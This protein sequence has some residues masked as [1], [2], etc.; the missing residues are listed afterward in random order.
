[1]SNSVLSGVW[2]FSQSAITL[3]APLLPGFSTRISS[4]LSSKM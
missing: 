3:R 1:M 4:L 2:N